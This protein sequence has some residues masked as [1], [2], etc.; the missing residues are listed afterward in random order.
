[1]SSDDSKGSAEEQAEAAKKVEEADEYVQWLEAREA[2]GTRGA[3]IDTAMNAA[4]EEAAADAIRAEADEPGS[5]RAQ[6]ARER[7]EHAVLDALIASYAAAF[8]RGAHRRREREATP[9]A[10]RSHRPGKPT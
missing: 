4:A 5:P 2:A 7:A 3:W 10:R 8:E 9:T 6:A 1:M